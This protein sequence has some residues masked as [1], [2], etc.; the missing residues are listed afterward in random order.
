MGTPLS[1]E[2]DHVLYVDPIKRQYSNRS[3]KLLPANNMHQRKYGSQ[4]HLQIASSCVYKL[5]EG[6]SGSTLSTNSN[7]RNRH[8][9]RKYDRIQC[10]YRDWLNYW[11]CQGCKE[12]SS[13]N[14]LNPFKSPLRKSNILGKWISK[15]IKVY[16]PMFILPP[17]KGKSISG[18]YRILLEFYI[19]INARISMYMQGLNIGIN[20]PTMFVY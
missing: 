9:I 20:N 14:I 10:I 17:I 11:M 12:I 1:I 19:P 6:N 13:A 5:G 8:A 3:D 15:S 7:L 18:F 2:Y 16:L 4:I